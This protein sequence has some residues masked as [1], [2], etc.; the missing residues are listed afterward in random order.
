MLLVKF[1]CL[2]RELSFVALGYYKVSL[3]YC[4]ELFVVEFVIF[5]EVLFYYYV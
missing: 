4:D 1:Y 2:S 5:E 3:L